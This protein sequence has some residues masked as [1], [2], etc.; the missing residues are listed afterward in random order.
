MTQRRT[1]RAAAPKPKTQVKDSYVNFAAR[2]GIGGGSIA[3][4]GQYQLTS[5]IT[6]QPRQLEFMYRGS[7]IVGV[8]VDAIADDMTRAG[9]D[10]G[11]ALPPDVIG[12]ME[13]QIEDTGLWQGVGDTIRWSRLYGGAVGVMQVDGQDM[14]TPLRPE[15]V[16]QGMFKGVVALGRW[17]LVPT[18]DQVISNLGPT[19]G[20][21]EFY[22]VGPN[23]SAL[24]NQI[25]HHSRVIRME[26]I[27][28]P[29]FQRIAEQGWGL[30]IVERMYDR[31]LAFDSATSGAAQLIFKAYLRTMKVQGLRKILAAGG[32][33]AEALAKNVEAIRQ[34]QSSEGITLVDG[35]DTFETHQYTFTGLD[36]VLL[37]FGQQLSG[38][39]EIPLVR[40]FGQSPSGMNATGE[41][42]IRN[43]YDTINAKQNRNLRLPMNTLLD[44]VFRS[45]T[46]DAPPKGFG[47]QFNSLWQMS[48][49]DKADIAKTI[50]DTVGAAFEDGII[51]RPTALRELKQSA[52]V[53]GVFSNITE[54]LI[55]EAENEPPEL[56]ELGLGQPPASVSGGI[57]A[58]SPPSP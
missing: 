38:A 35:E 6:R 29:Y 34:Y 45:T 37:Q 52:D 22:Q 1:T 2:L 33:A 19:L 23:A 48:E 46:G 13:G 26:G 15:T 42:D 17:E 36:D 9:V 16:G 21:P 43:Y 47:Y 12:A 28:L 50:G 51:D 14:A 11:S 41:S 30:S 32:P 8:A 39:T 24:Q 18:I 10:F 7:W 4:A 44:L 31:L 25:V 53:T 5:I 20:D 55:T 56:G 58:L 3:D 57:D 54:E 27:R 40:L 49:K